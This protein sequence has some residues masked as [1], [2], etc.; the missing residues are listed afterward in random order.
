MTEEHV[1]H[2]QH[3]NA[4]PSGIEC[5]DVVEHLSFNIGNAVKYLWRHEHKNGIEDLQK[6]K[7]YIEREIKRLQNGETAAPLTAQ[8]IVI[9][10][11]D[12]PNFH[13]WCMPVRGA[14][15][16][17]TRTCAACGLTIARED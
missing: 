8:E 1:N 15:G 6:A 14:D 2:P 16:T 5:I 7:W 13:E 10:S 12:D 11:P 17:V 3:Y 9:C 4:L